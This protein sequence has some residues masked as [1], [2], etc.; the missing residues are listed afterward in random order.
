[1]KKLIA[2]GYWNDGNDGCPLHNPQ[3]FVDEHLDPP[4]RE[5]MAHYLRSGVVC[6]SSPGASWCRFACDA[7]AEALGSADLSDGFWMWPEGLV[8]YVERHAVTLPEAFVEHARVRGFEVRFEGLDEPGHGE[9]EFWN[10]WCDVHSNE[11]PAA[12]AL[13]RRT[14]AQVAADLGEIIARLTEKHGGLGDASCSW[15]GC[16]R[17]VLRGLAF[18]PECAH[19]RMQLWP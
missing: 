18:C 8:H 11:D 16:G 6:A 4:V 14:P 3:E 17:R 13:W 1:V 9:F 15:I 7:P 10:E 12:I 2:I 19:L 5:A